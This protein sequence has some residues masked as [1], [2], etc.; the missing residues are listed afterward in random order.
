M[1]GCGV[2]YNLQVPVAVGVGW[3]DRSSGVSGDCVKGT[4]WGGAAAWVRGAFVFSID[5]GD[6][7]LGR[8]WWESIEHIFYA[9]WVA[10]FGAGERLGN[11]AV[12]GGVVG[13]VGRRLGNDRDS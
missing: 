4:N 9:N 5:A 13:W 2:E 6:D 3:G 7:G 1:R 10:L 11:D 8:L 12:H